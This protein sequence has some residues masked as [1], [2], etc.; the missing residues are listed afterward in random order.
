VGEA[1]EECEVTYVAFIPKTI[2]P[3]GIS[4]LKRGECVQIISRDPEPVE[5]QFRPLRYDELHSVI[6][7]KDVRERSGYLYYWLELRLAP[8]PCCLHKE[9]GFFV[10]L[11]RLNE[12]LL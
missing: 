7:P 1:I 3:A 11:F 10:D 6:V 12:G 2:L 8:T 5:V 4:R 9:P